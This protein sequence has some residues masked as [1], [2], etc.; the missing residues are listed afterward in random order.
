[1]TNPYEYGFQYRECWVQH[2]NIDLEYYLLFEKSTIFYNDKGAFLTPYP[3]NI[4]CYV[5]RKWYTNSNGVSGE[6]G[7]YTI[8]QGTRYAYITDS[9][10]GSGYTTYI[11]FDQPTL[12]RVHFLDDSQHNINERGSSYSVADG[13]YATGA[14]FMDVYDPEFSI[15]KVSI[16]YSASWLWTAKVNIAYQETNHTRVRLLWANSA[17]SG[18]NRTGYIYITVSNVKG[19]TYYHTVTVNQKGPSGSGSG[20]TGGG[21]NEEATLGPEW[22]KGS[23]PGYLPYWYCPNT[24]KTIPYTPVA[25]NITIYKNSNTGAYK[26]AYAGKLYNAQ[27]G[28]NKITISTEAHSVYDSTYDFWKSCLDRYYLEFTIY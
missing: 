3:T 5:Y 13:V 4:N 15:D 8:P 1:M 12:E 24:G 18:S 14:C 27:R 9:D 17:N 23:A 19:E 28:Y 16:S 22:V 21:S 26:A 20:G 10:T 2:Y 11:L 6:E 25:G 7:I